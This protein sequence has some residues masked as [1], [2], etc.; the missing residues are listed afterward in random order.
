MVHND[1]AGLL[2]KNHYKRLLAF[3]SVSVT[4]DP[5]TRHVTNRVQ[6]LVDEFG[7][8][9]K[10]VDCA[11]RMEAYARAVVKYGLPRMAHLAVDDALEYLKK[12]NGPRDTQ[13]R[14][15]CLPY[16]T[17]G[18]IHTVDR[19]EIDGFR[20]MR[21][22]IERYAED[23]SFRGK[24]LRIA[25][26]GA[27]GSGKGFTIKQILRNVNSSKADS[28][29][30][31]I[32]LSQLSDGDSL[33]EAFH[34]VQDRALVEDLPLVVFDEFDSLPGVQP[35]PFGWLKLFLA[36]MQD[37]TFVRKVK[38]YHIGRAIFLFAGGVSHS[39]SC[40]E[41]SVMRAEKGESSQ[42][43]KG[44]TATESGG[45]DPNPRSA[46]SNGAPQETDARDARGRPVAVN[47]RMSTAVWVSTG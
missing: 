39:Y 14:L 19:N 17:F 41:S 3:A 8:E 38:T 7:G 46:L 44:A 18:A 43:D 27:P 35:Q 29:G 20:T 33:M 47:R 31:E 1:N 16:A 12:T 26:F 2:K 32:N 37:G 4:F 34:E 23:R 42:K 10:S 45:E 21:A 22:L 6:S 24:P 40:F 15:I 13:G 9:I 36:P 28:K 5:N 30:L 25:V 11:D